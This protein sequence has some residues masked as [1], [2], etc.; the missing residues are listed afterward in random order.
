MLTR[1]RDDAAILGAHLLVNSRKFNEIYKI[2]EL[3]YFANV[4]KERIEAAARDEKE[5]L[6][7]EARKKAALDALDA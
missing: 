7:A 1:L 5:K 4:E 3:E 2:K 6:E